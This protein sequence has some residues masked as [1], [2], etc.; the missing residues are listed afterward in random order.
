M[1][2]RRRH[3]QLRRLINRIALAVPIDDYAI[4]AA[5]DHVVDLTL[6]LCRIR[7]AVAVVHVA[8]LAEP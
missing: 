6:H 1:A 2:F 4:D 7:L 5:A 3:H 8:R